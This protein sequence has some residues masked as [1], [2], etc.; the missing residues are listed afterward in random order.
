MLSRMV[1]EKCLIKRAVIKLR[2]ISE[3]DG[4]NSILNQLIEISR[5]KNN[6]LLLDTL[7]ISLIPKP[8]EILDI[9]LGDILFGS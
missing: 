2:L 6:L 4:R 3:S 9:C 5:C 7:G 1:E 8:R